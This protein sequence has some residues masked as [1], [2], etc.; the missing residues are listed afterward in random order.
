MLW[1]LSQ[2]IAQGIRGQRGIDDLWTFCGG[3]GDSD[4]DESRTIKRRTHK[5]SPKSHEH[6]QHR[7]RFLHFCCYV[8]YTRMTSVNVHVWGQLF[9][10]LQLLDICSK[11]NS[12]VYRFFVFCFTARAFWF[13][14]DWRSASQKGTRTHT[15]KHERLTTLQNIGLFGDWQETYLES[16]RIS[17]K[18][19]CWNVKIDDVISINIAQY[20]WANLMIT[21]ELAVVKWMVANPKENSVWKSHIFS[22]KL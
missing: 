14:R 1:F 21:N 22:H 16:A 13:G 5:I 8:S 17:G 9:S 12:R 20:D 7:S 4:D 6:M 2:D 10:W 19:S 18:M 11:V 15:S 3:G